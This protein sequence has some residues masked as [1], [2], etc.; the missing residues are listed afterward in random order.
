MN[1]YTIQALPL[2]LTLAQFETADEQDIKQQVNLEVINDLNHQNITQQVHLDL[3]VIN[4]NVI[5]QAQQLPVYLEN[6]TGQRQTIGY[7]TLTLVDQA[8]TSHY[9]IQAEPLTMRVKV[10]QNATSA[11]LLADAH[12]VVKRSNAR[13]DVTSQVTVDKSVVDTN[14]LNQ[15]Q[16]LPLFIS[17]SPNER[18]KVG[19]ITLTLT[20]NAHKHHFKGWIATIIV[21]VGGVV[22]ASVWHQHH[23]NQTNNTI[24]TQQNSQI[25]N[26]QNQLSQHGTQL[27]KDEAAIGKLKQQV[28]ALKQAVQDYQQNQN[29]QQFNNALSQIQQ[30]INQIKQQDAFQNQVFTALLNRI[31]QAL[32]DLEQATPQQ[33]NQILSKYHLN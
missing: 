12:V 7:L 30:E 6:S 18:Q 4:L 25:S 20:G 11:Q 19:A 27:A 31:N 8:T 5:N 15:V 13:L 16:Y 22:L 26:N 14:L 28:V 23:V 3:A 1:T 32:N 10:F 2:R 33:A 21:V 9:E 17:P 29:K 24:N